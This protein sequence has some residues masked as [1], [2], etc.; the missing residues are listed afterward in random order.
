MWKRWGAFHVSRWRR[1]TTW[2]DI[3]VSHPLSDLFG[4]FLQAYQTH[5][6]SLGRIVRLYAESN[7]TSNRDVSIIL[8]QTA[9]ETLA[10]VWFGA[11]SG[12]EGVWINNA[13]KEFLIP[14]HVPGRLPALRQHARERGWEHGPHAIVELR[15]PLVHSRQNA[16]STASGVEHEARQLA[17]W[18]VELAVLKV[19]GFRGQHACRLNQVHRPGETELVPWSQG[20]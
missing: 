12:A 8:A 9:L 5:R 10:H 7:A 1:A 16:I 4:E 3:T 13:L 20:C 2:Y 17:L 6:N 15:N 18:F 11:K 19:L 14:T